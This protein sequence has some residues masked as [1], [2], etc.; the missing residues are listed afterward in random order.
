[1]S[2]MSALKHESNSGDLNLSVTEN[3]ALGYRTSGKALVDMTFAL[4]SLRQKDDRA[5]QSMF[6]AVCSEDIDL[7]VVWLMWARDV[8]GGAGERRLFR[9]CFEYLAREFPEK[10]VKVVRLIAEY[11]RW[12]DVV[13]IACSDVPEIV[14]NKAL[15]IIKDQLVEDCK[16][17]Y[18]N[19]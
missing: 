2:F 16:A 13:E 5:V 3:G 6:S 10:A 17:C 15:S 14:K 19:V 11:G 1:M 9:V 7:A 4:S 18:I 12:D 8:R